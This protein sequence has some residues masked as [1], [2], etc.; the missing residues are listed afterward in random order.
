[1]I[2]FP[3]RIL[4][5]DVRACRSRNRD[6]ASQI[7]KTAALPGPGPRALRKRREGVQNEDR[8]ALRRPAFLSYPALRSAVL[9]FS[10]SR[11]RTSMV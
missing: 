3:L 6:G 1:M 4:A 10:A 7:D 9:A 2:L 8:A 11:L 5:L